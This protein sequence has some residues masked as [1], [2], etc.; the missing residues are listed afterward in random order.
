MYLICGEA[1]FDLFAPADARA[2]FT[3][4]ARAGGAPF[5]VAVGMARLGARAGLFTALSNDT[6]GRA[7]RAALEEDGVN[8]R[9]LLESP[10]ETALSLVTL[11][12]RGDA[13]YRFYGAG[14]AERMIDASDLPELPD[15]VAGLHFGSYSMVVEPVAGAHLALAGREAGRR[16]IS[17]DPNVRPTIEPDMAVW[18]RAAEAMANLADIVKVSA[19]DAAAIWPGRPFGD[20]LDWFRACGAAL[21]I[22]TDGAN[23]ALA[24]GGFGEVFAAPV[25]VPVVDTVGA[26]DAFQAA[27]LAEIQ[28]RAPDRRALAALER[29]QVGE[30]MAVAS[31]AAAFT[32]A[33]AGADMPRRGDIARIGT[34]DAG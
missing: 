1:L 25:R 12:A 24:R 17:W 31:A 27:A 18:A 9:F 10:R 19:E 16:L 13:A 7:L 15:A 5:N 23:G 34:D 22:G 2:P 6:F 28:A 8:T 30:I 33:R 4:S 26:G 21:V 32:C 20:V 29:D 11:G 14:T 3:L